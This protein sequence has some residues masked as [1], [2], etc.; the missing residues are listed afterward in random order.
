M[1]YVLSSVRRLVRCCVFGPRIGF[2]PPRRYFNSAALSS[3]LPGVAQHLNIYER[4]RGS[5][6]V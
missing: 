5:C 1:R 6:F 4:E 2:F 3:I